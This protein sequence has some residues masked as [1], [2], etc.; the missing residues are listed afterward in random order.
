[1]GTLGRYT[2]YVGKLTAAHTLLGKLFSGGPLAKFQATGD[3]TGAQA[4]AGTR[5]TAKVDA[6]G[7]G[8]LVPSAGVQRHNVR[9][10]DCSCIG[11]QPGHGS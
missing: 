1:M 8:G 7:V 6:S 3:E 10:N 4:D 2:Q 9:R 5:G 11:S